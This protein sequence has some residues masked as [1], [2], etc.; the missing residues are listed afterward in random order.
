MHIR[1]V[2][3]FAMLVVFLSSGFAYS[4]TAEKTK[5]DRV[6]KDGMMV[7]LDYTLKN[8]EGKTLETSKGREPLRYIHGQ[9]MMIPGLE[10]E[11][12]GM[13]VGG[14]KHVTVKPEDGYGKVNPNAVQEFP[15]EKIP[16]N[17]LKVGAV[18]AA[19]SP[20]GMV[21]PMT[22]REIKEKTVVMDLNHPMAGKTLVFDVKV[23]DIQP[24]PPPP[25]QP[26]KPIAPTKPVTPPAPAKQSEP[27]NPAEPAKK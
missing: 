10:K 26:A 21:V 13:K 6:V 3:L 8:P 24:A 27:A 16:A 12:T 20:E 19:R 15:K 22:V 25:A 7:S 14:E 4:A 23:V 17:A 18:L 2:S 1:F 9:K 5:N 11:L